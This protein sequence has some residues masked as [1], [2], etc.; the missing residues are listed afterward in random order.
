MTGHSHQL[1]VLSLVKPLEVDILSAPLISHPNPCS[2]T[3]LRPCGS[4][5]HSPA[6]DDILQLCLCWPSGSWFTGS[7]FCGSGAHGQ[8]V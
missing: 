5:Y 1:P 6:D 4:N 3:L 8:N 7:T 2:P